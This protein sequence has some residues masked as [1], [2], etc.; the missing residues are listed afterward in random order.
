[1]TPDEAQRILDMV[2][3]AQ[4]RGDKN[5]YGAVVPGAPDW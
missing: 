1:M 3:E 4:P 5:A 2:E